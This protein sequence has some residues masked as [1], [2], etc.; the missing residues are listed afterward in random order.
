MPP[1]ERHYSVSQ[2]QTYLGCALKYRFQ[3][4]ELI[5]KAFRPAARAFGGSIHAA[6]EWLNRARMTGERPPFGEVLR[7]FQADWYAQ[8]LEPLAFAA[9]EGRDELE[10]KGRAML[11]VYFDSLNGAVPRAVEEP[12]SLDLA[13]PESGELLDVPLRGVVDLVEADGTLVDLKTAGRAVA[14]QDVERHLQLS[15][16]ALATY[17]LQGRVPPLRLDVLLKTR[18]PRLERYPTNR[19]IPE[20]SWTARLIRSVVEAIEAG[21]FFPNPSWRCAECEYFAACQR[22]RG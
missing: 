17:L 22:W 21:K 20:L 14:P 19:S 1:E 15:T 3:Y 12:F 9:S 5:P 8:N 6:V 13:D 10:G 11:Q 16:Y 2:V 7:Q 18:T 4:R